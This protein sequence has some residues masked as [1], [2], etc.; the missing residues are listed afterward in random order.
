MP[1]VARITATSRAFISSWVPSRVMVFIQLMLPAGAPARAAASAMSSTDRVM[2]RA[3][4]GWGLM[5]MGQRA[6][7]AINTLYI[8]V[9]VG[10]VDGTMAATTPNGSAISTIF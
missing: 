3:A 9:D 2:Q 10:L 5:T 1:P 6:L 7:S 8:A 4:D